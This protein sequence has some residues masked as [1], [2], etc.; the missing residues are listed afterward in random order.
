M[1][2]A[3]AAV[4]STDLD[5][6]LSRHSA[7][8][9][10]YLDDPFSAHFLPPAYRR[11][12]ERRPPLINIGTHARTWAVDE[13]V[14]QFLSRAGG[15]DRQGEVQVLSLGAG[16]DTRFWRMR[17][18]WEDAKSALGE[19]RCRRWV[20]V[21]FPEQTGAK[22]RVVSSK[23]AFRSQ[24]GGDVKIG[25]H[26]RP[27]QREGAMLIFPF[28]PPFS[29]FSAELGGQGLTSPLYALL[30]GDLRD[31]SSLSSLLLSPVPSSPSKPPILDPT[32]PT[33]LLVECV[34]VYLEPG[35][36]DALLGWFSSTFGGDSAMVS[37]DPFSL[38]DS[39]GTVMR[40]NLAVRPSS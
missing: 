15:G 26:L 28:Y 33:L 34:L 35:V 25:A 11:N 10:D 16:T 17:K 38:E 9:L 36:T 6:L 23:A 14:Q 18:K 30:P 3:D 19:W 12:P 40:R 31:L 22:A 24:L 39:F 7:A 2:T 21:D 8:S 1:T 27:L 4:R 13:L 32:L 37:Y 29:S 5:A 20:E